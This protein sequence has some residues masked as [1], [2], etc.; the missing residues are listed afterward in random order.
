MAGGRAAR[1]NSPPARIS[2]SNLTFLIMG[3]RLQATERQRMPAPR[4]ARSGD[5]RSVLR[6]T[7]AAHASSC[8]MLAA[9]V[10]GLALLLLPA[11]ASADGIGMAPLSSSRPGDDPAAAASAH[12]TASTAA[13]GTATRSTSAARSPHAQRDA[14]KLGQGCRRL[15]IP[16][17]PARVRSPPTRS[18]WQRGREA[19]PSR[20]APP[21][22]QLPCM[23]PCS[24]RTCVVTVTQM[25]MTNTG[26]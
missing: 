14:R 22:P 23:H 19:V 24:A 3:P 2:G 1:T 13:T 25:T 8:A 10:M 11:S 21:C 20:A 16:V 5:G 6:P 12:T 18:G 4:P 15:R 7:A 9:L 26:G 17:I